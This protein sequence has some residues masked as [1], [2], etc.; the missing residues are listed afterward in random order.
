MQTSQSK[1]NEICT[2]YKNVLEFSDDD[3]DHDESYL[4]SPLFNTFST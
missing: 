1:E 2:D 3:I 4:S